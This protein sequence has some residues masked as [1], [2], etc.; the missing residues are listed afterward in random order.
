MSSR[1]TTTNSRSVKRRCLRPMHHPQHP[2]AS[3]SAQ[4]AA[5]RR[6]L[7][8]AIQN[9]AAD[10]NSH[11]IHN[12]HDSHARTPLTVPY[13]PVFYP[14]LEDFCGNPL[15]Y[16]EKIRP[17]A[18]RYG[19]AK[20]VPPP[21]WNPGPYFGASRVVMLGLLSSL[22]MDCFALVFSLCAFVASFFALRV[23]CIHKR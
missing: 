14:T 20:I 18:E 22:W 16:V 1:A 3:C 15:H 6:C 5:E 21:G 9:H 12:H 19:I 11:N 17:E 4:L 23:H 7:N 13:A 2:T 10:R 8:Q